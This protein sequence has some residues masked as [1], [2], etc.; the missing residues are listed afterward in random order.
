MFIQAF[1][2][3]VG[4]GQAVEAHTAIHRTHHGVHGLVAKHTSEVEQVIRQ[5]KLVIQNDFQYRTHRSIKQSAFNGVVVELDEHFDLLKSFFV[6]LQSKV[7]QQ[8]QLKNGELSPHRV[9]IKLDTDQ[10]DDVGVFVNLAVVQALHQ[11]R[12]L[13]IAQDMQ[14]QNIFPEKQSTI[15]VIPDQI[16]YL[17]NLGIT[18][19]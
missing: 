9:F 19:H 2:L 3:H 13:L 8:F 4:W 1:Q 10:G 15:G 12:Q 11:G 5:L 6:L 14:I 16:L 18:G 17:I 7:D